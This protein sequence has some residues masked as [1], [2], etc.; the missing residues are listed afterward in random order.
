MQIFVL[1]DYI[2]GVNISIKIRIL[3]GKD[4]NPRV[5]SHPVGNFNEQPP[6]PWQKTANNAMHF[7]WHY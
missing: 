6:L 3:K 5:N 1:G 2:K 7:P 4:L